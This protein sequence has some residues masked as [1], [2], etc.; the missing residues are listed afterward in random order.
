MAD[1]L[2][3]VHPCDNRVPVWDSDIINI[4][5]L[6]KSGITLQLKINKVNGWF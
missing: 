6:K 3:Y 5:I 2:L 1:M 4:R